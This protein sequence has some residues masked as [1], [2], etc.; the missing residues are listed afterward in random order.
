M[1][2]DALKFFALSGGDWV[3][4]GLLASSVVAVGV[5][6]ER[7]LLLRRESEALDRLRAGLETPLAEGDRAGIGGALK[8]AEGA[9]ARILSRSLQTG[10]R[11]A[12]EDRVTAAALDE[13]RFLEKRLL[14][15]GTLGS[16]AP[17]VGLF[18]TVLGVIRAFHDL[19]EHSGAGPEIVMK[20]LSEALIATAVGLFVAIPSVIAYN[21]LQKQVKDLLSGVESLSRLILATG[22]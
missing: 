12:A 7:G 4:W 19:A 17:F 21:Y 8:A 16:N 10:A 22:D 18:G 6:L 5:I 15:L 1:N 13:R 2:L 9:G 3:I 11:A 14:I 20:G